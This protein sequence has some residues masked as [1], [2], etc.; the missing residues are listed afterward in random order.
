MT[1]KNEVTV[2]LQAPTNGFPVNHFFNRFFT[3]TVEDLG[4]LVHTTYQASTGTNMGNFSFIIPFADIERQKEDILRY[5]ESVG[6]TEPQQA[7]PQFYLGENPIHSVRYIHA[8]RTDNQAEL[9]LYNIPI[10]QQNRL[11]SDKKESL[12]ADPIAA[13]SSF[14]SVHLELLKQVYAR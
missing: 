7:F 10:F 4:V 2:D 8:G 6:D 1:K 3:E 13:L 14:V 11:S 12:A 5:V 9:L